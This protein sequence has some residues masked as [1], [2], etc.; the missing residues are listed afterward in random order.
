MSQIIQKLPRLYIDQ[1]LAQGSSLEASHDVAHYLGHVLRFKSNDQ[2]RIFNGRDG[3]WL[4]SIG[5]I[6]K[7]SV[8]L[9]ALEQID[10]QHFPP[11]DI[12]LI[13]API[14]K[15]RQDFLIEKAVELGVTHLYP[16]LT[17]YS[18]VRKINQERV[19]RQIIEA[20]EQ[21]ERQDIPHLYKLQS[22][23]ELLEKWP[24]SIP[25]MYCVERAD[26]PMM[27]T[28]DLSCNIGVFIGPEGGLSDTEKGY[29]E[30][31]TAVSL[32]PSVLRSETAVVSALAYI[33]MQ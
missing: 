11:R 24:V 6:S 12:H 4:C 33:M 5:K 7:K 20:A 29:A 22:L 10:I 32:G 23:D 3:D 19:E 28:C 21:C 15:T 17:E 16:V 26:V 30:R 8:T 25:L 14:K 31:F 18:H 2:V 27:S 9:E 1:D 13:F